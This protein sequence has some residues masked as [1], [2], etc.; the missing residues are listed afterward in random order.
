VG[1]AVGVVGGGREAVVDLVAGAEREDG[2][3]EGGVVRRR[4]GGVGGRHSGDGLG[5]RRLGLDLAAAR[6]ERKSGMVSSAS[7]SVPPPTVKRKRKGVE[8]DYR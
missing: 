4:R 1:A 3:A 5:R 2:A 7:P 6:R 8:R